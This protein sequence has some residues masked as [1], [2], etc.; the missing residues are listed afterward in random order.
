[1]KTLITALKIARAAAGGLKRA[2]AAAL[3]FARRLVIYACLAAVLIAD[4]ILDRVAPKAT[5][6]K[7]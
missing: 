3:D 7:P 2:G 5:G 1:M 4:W 6:N